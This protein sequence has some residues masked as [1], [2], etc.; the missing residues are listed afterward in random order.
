MRKR[1]CVLITCA[2]PAL[3]PFFV[4]ADTESPWAASLGL[5]TTGVTA[6]LFYRETPHFVANL[7]A[8]GFAVDPSFSAGG[9]NYHM[10]IRLLSARLAEDWYPFN[11]NLFLAAGVLFNSDK[12]SLQPAATQGNY[13][14]ATPA[15]F[16]FS[17]VAP[18]LGVG[19]GYPFSGSRWTFLAET[20]AAYEGSPKI[21]VAMGTNP[22]A[23]QAYQAEKSSI[24]AALGGCHWYPVAQ[25]SLVY[26]FG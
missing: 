21:S 26:R 13:S 5:G 3:F 18:Y 11:G 9:E 1:I 22:Y 17:P 20:G 6:G 2:A 25:A 8:G 14:F 15:S 24:S 19:W 23:A 16:R 10:G 4:H 7:D 12:F